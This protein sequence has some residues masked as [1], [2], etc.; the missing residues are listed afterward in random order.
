VVAAQAVTAGPVRR[1]LAVAAWVV[2]LA[3]IAAYLAWFLHGNE[4][5]SGDNYPSH[6][7]AVAWLQSGNAYDLG[8]IRGDLPEQFPELFRVGNIYPLPTTLIIGLP[9]A[10]LQPSAAAVCLTALLVTGI[11]LAAWWSRTGPAVLW[12]L[13]FLEAVS[14]FQASLLTM[15]GYLLLWGARRRGLVWVVALAC[16]VLSLRPQEG[17][18]GIIVAVWWLRRDAWRIAV[19]LAALW[20]PSFAFQ[21]DWLG[22][23]IDVATHRNGLLAVQPVW[24]FWFVVP[25]GLI[26]IW[27]GR[28]RSPAEREGWTLSGLTVVQSGLLPWV[29]PAWYP[30]IMWLTGLPRALSRVVVV[31]PFL[32]C[33]FLPAPV[34]LA[35]AMAIGLL[36]FLW[37]ESRQA[38]HST[39]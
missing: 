17:L 26:V 11:A 32:V 3:C 15:L 30:G 12:W 4:L 39:Q 19:V 1:V 31:L 29:V 27:L 37:Q 22:R 2:P 16:G 28:S 13:P 25:L 10:W 9:F 6:W 14:I 35:V 38:L 24:V 8:A 23:W 20:L 34:G 36:V 18:V 33:L 21:P 7:G 5:I